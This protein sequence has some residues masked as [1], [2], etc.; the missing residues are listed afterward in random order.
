MGLQNVTQHKR[1]MDIE[2]GKPDLLT[3]LFHAQFRDVLL[4]RVLHSL[5]AFFVFLPVGNLLLEAFQLSAEPAAF[6]SQG[7]NVT[8]S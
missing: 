2:F 7:H 4:E 1:I 6:L 8:I 3:D 5:G